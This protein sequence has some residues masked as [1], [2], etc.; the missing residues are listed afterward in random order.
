MQPGLQALE[1]EQC[2]LEVVGSF[3][4]S[5][6]HLLPRQHGPVLHQLGFGVQLQ[7]G[8]VDR[9][10]YRTWVSRSVGQCM[11]SIARGGAWAV[12]MCVPMRVCIGR[13]YTVRRFD[14]RAQSAQSAQSTT[15]T[16]QGR[17][18]E[19]PTDPG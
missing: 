3:D 6:P 14:K 10:P 19:D 17:S 11:G 8:G 5:E 18:D 16:V 2:H 9:G 13:A 15:Q 4:S 7:R 12:W 1:L